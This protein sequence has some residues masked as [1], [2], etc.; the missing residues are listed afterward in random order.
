MGPTAAA[1]VRLSGMRRCLSGL[2]TTPCSSLFDRPTQLVLRE[3]SFLPFC[4]PSSAWFSS[5]QYV[6]THHPPL[7]INA[8]SSRCVHTATTVATA[9][10][11]IN[12][13]LPGFKRMETNKLGFLTR[14]IEAFG[15]I[16]PLKHSKW[17]LRIAA[18][19]MYTCC[20]E[21][22]DFEDFVKQCQLPDTL[23]TWFLVT[24][25]HVWMCLVRLKQEGREGNYI[26][27]YIVYAMWDDLQQRGA[28]MKINETQIKRS[29]KAMT[30]VFYASLFG[31]DE[32]ILSEDHV[33][34]AALWRHLFSF[35]LSDPRH[36]ELMVEYVRKQVQYLDSFNSEDLLLTGVI[37]WRPLHEKNPESVL[38]AD[39]P[40]Y[41]DAGL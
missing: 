10:A 28:M 41:N 17:K 2:G 12:T 23:S 38:K 32:G 16:G 34:L 35:N 25:L 31:Y 1:V 14:I 4:S 22:V 27:K 15:F 40:A 5:Q 21:K 26:C 11:A 37:R 20:V 30:E 36:L 7:C 39:L 29:M 9:T 33:L 24:Q 18:L 13:K 19:R 3:R 6:S 8:P